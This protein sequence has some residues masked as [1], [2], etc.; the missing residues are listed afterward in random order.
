[1]RRFV[2]RTVLALALSALI[3]V[4]GASAY[5]RIGQYRFRRQAEQLL[6]DVRGLELGKTGSSDVARVAKKW[7]FAPSL[8]QQKVC[9]N[10]SCEYFLE[11]TTPTAKAFEIAH[12]IVQEATVARILTLLGRRPAI[13]HVRLGVRGSVMRSEMFSVSLLVQGEEGDEEYLIAMASTRA[14]YSYRYQPS[15]KLRNWLRHPGYLVG[16]H[17]GVISQDYDPKPAP[18]IW[19]EFSNSARIS[20][21]S[22]L[23]QFDLGCLTRLRSCRDGD[24]MPAAWAEVEEDRRVI[25]PVITCG[26]EL[27]KQLASLADVVAVVRLTTKVHRT[28]GY[29]GYTYHLPNVEI[30]RFIRTPEF[31][32]SFKTMDI[33]VGES[34]TPM[35]ADT[36]DSVL[37]GEQY[38]AFIDLTG[39][40]PCGVLTLN[41]ANLAMVRAAAANEAD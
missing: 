5:L 35:V 39:L 33:K 23:T 34:S 13:I 38:I 1:M 26:P 24:L 28:P 11:L 40:Y 2:K 17:R 12:G 10:D 29:E 41:D 31:W 14:D 7:G 32:R 6:E 16:E 15:D 30:V 20:D 4:A 19:V 9:T 27:A 8:P 3:L 25:H 21:I 22:R 37:P 36:G 18:T